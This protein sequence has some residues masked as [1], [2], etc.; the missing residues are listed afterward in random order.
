MASQ[1][2]HLAVVEALLAA[3]ADK[4]AITEHGHPAHGIAIQQGHLA[5]AEAL[6]RA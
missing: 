2:G 3:G 4:D 5:V 6:Q 1:N